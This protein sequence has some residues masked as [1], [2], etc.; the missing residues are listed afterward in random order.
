MRR[1]RA[2]RAM[3][4]QQGARATQIGLSVHVLVPVLPPVYP[5]SPGLRRTRTTVSTHCDSD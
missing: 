4:T 3:P 1:I 2:I 5:P